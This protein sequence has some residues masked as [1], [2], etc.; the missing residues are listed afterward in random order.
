MLVVNMIQHLVVNNKKAYKS[1]TC[2]LKVQSVGESKN[3]IDKK[4]RA[5]NR[6]S[7]CHLFLESTLT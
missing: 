6:N 3:N 2:R 5:I 1:M 7:K 4:I